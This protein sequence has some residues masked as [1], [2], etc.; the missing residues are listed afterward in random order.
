M[1]TF[2]IAL[3]GAIMMLFSLSSCTDKYDVEIE[4]TQSVK[5]TAAHIFDN[6]EQFQEGDFDMGADGWK[7]NLQVLVYDEN[8]ILVDKK[9]KLCESLSETLEYMPSLRE[10]VC[11]VISIADFREGLGGK[12]YKFWNITND[13]SLQDISI[14][15]N[16]NIY[17]VVFETLGVDIQKLVVSDKTLTVNADIKPVTSLVQVFMSDKDYSSWGIDG[18]S[19]YSVLCE[20]YFIKAIKFKNNIRI[21]NGELS[22]KYSEQVSDYNIAISHVYEKWSDK[23]APTGYN[24]RALLPEDNK[25][26]SFRIQKRDLPQDYY[27][28]AVQLCGEFDT[29]GKSNILPRI[30]SNK[31]YV[32]NMILDA[33][34]LVAME[35]PSD[36]THEAYTKQYVSDYNMRLMEKMVDIKYENILGKDEAYANVFLD[37]EP[38]EHS[39]NK[40]PYIAYYKRSRADHFEQFVTTAYVNAD[41][42][43]CLEVNLLLPDLSDELFSYLKTILG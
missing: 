41:Y 24:Y 27:D 30:E 43:N 15:E 17:P 39:G 7:L 38:Y 13:M 36:F 14:T 42:T 29:E 16:E 34:Q 3:L 33:M 25:G 28:V 10:G 6:Y 23:K 1:K 32:V 20:G 8:G 40:I 4:T 9:E 31:Q 22:Y 2:L 18:Y 12:G 21:E 37:D 5:V 26:F 35:L 19:R 11:T